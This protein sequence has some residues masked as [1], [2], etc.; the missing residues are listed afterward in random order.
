MERHSQR[1][2]RG[3]PRPPGRACSGVLLR[4]F[5]DA[6]VMGPW[7]DVAVDEQAQLEHRTAKSKD[8]AMP[9]PTLQPTTDGLV[10]IRPPGPGDAEALV[11]GRDEAFH[12]WLGPGAE[13]PEP[14]ACIVVAGEIAGWVD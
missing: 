7:R 8:S 14:V 13:E 11:A 1:S 12:R 4:R 10:T 9:G 5:H 3:S 2:H 6:W